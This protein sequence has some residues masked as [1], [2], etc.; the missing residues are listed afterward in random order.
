MTHQGLVIRLVSVGPS[1]YGGQQ[2]PSGEKSMCSA[3]RALIGVALSGLTGFGAVS[4]SAE[5]KALGPYNIPTDAYIVRYNDVFA[6]VVSEAGM[7]SSQND[8]ATR[9]GV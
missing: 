4:A 7:V 2:A 8:I 1:H 6:P 9:V 5:E 3:A